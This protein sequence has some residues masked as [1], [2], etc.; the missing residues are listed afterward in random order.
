MTS[1]NYGFADRAGRFADCAGRFADRARGCGEGAIL[2]RSCCPC[3]V[4][5]SPPKFAQRI[6]LLHAG[7]EPTVEKRRRGTES[8]GARPHERRARLSRPRMLATVR[9]IESGSPGLYRPA[10]RIVRLQVLRA[11]PR[12][13][14]IGTPEYRGRIRTVHAG[15]ICAVSWLCAS[16]SR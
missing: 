16:V 12:L 4:H 11:D 6:C 7:A 3:E 15:R 10:A 2:V 1:E 14:C 13:E 8:A 5:R 9:R